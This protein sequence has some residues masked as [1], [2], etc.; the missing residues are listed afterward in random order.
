MLK[1]LSVSSFSFGLP[2]AMLS[3]SFVT[4][5]TGKQSPYKNFKEPKKLEENQHD[6]S[7]KNRSEFR[8]FPESFR[9]QNAPR[10]TYRSYFTS[11]EALKYNFIC[12]YFH[13][14]LHVSKLNLAQN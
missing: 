6:P 13:K 11:A 2:C 4:Q 10:S 14:G 3:P 12:V 1:T 7:K 8:P 9:T 5:S